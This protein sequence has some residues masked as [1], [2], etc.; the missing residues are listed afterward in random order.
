[1]SK[2]EPILKIEPENELRFRGPFKE[3]VSVVMKLTNTTEKKACFKVKTTAPKRYCVKPT[4]GVI[5]PKGVV[6]ILVTLQPF[7]P[8]DPNEKGK[9]KF[10]VLSVHAPEGEF[11]IE[12]LWKETSLEIND[13]KLKCVLEVPE[14]TEAAAASTPAAAANSTDASSPSAAVS[15]TASA[16]APVS[17]NDGN[18]SNDGSAKRI[19]SLESDLGRA[20][21]EIK[22]LRE[23]V[24]LMTKEN[25]Q[26]K[27]EGIRLRRVNVS[28]SGAADSLSFKT[29]Q[30][31]ASAYR[32]HGHDT[33]STTSPPNVLYIVVALLM[34]II[35]AKLFF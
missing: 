28:G 14:A 7:D 30:P 23:E 31:A 17:K 12:T 3:P 21:E 15:A 33:V 26:L 5:D 11:N 10:Q 32:P 29:E 13:W 4:T 35:M 8:N 9:H 16:S 25:I 20:A 34:G 24:S 27:E 2:G 6:T 22:R 18:T 19:S 1:M